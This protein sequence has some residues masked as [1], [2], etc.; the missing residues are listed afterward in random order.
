MS[1]TVLVPYDGSEQADRAVDHAI[2]RFSDA[3]V[4]L[5]T[6]INPAESVYATG[7][8]AVSP[9]PENWYEGAQEQAE[10]MVE[11]VLERFEEEGISVKSDIEVGRPGRAIIQYVDENEVDHIVMGSHGR[12]G[13]SRILL[14]SVA[15]TVMRRSPVPVTVI[16]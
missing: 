10:H 3:D 5:L 11:G 16:R 7:E 6:V 13:V 12:S 2:E 9:F 8:G 14:G 4:V 1:P 15:E